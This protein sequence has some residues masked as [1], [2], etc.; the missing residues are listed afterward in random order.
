MSKVTIYRY[1]VVDT[2]RGKPRLARRWGTRAAIAS[3]GWADIL[4]NTATEVRQLRAERRRLHSSGFRP[5]VLVDYSA[6]GTHNV[7]NLFVVV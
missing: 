5:E 1:K 7:G 4:E 3:L 2:D 6:I